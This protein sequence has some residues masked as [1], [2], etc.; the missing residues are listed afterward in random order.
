MKKNVNLIWIYLFLLPT[1]V[2]FMAFYAIPIVTMVL[3]SFTRWDGYNAPVFNGLT[4]YL[5]L[6]SQSAFLISLKNLFFWSAIAAVFHVGYGV[7]VA[8]I[9]YSKP[10]GWRFVRSV[11]MIPNVISAAALAMI[12]KFIFVDQYGLL[13]NL[14]R[15]A[16]P[17]FYI[18][19]FYQSPY[20]FWAVTFTWLFYAVIVTLIVMTDLYA[21]PPT[22]YESAVI[23]G[24]TQWDIS[25]KIN[26]PLCR[27]AIGTGVILSVTSRISMYVNIALTTRGGPGQDTTN[28]TLLQVRGI[29]DMHYGFANATSVIMLILGLLIL[30]VINKAFKM[31]ESVYF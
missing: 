26:L 18:N 23:D 7:L 27:N 9:L 8:F 17:D 10:F 31:K 13:N 14:V 24:A 29:T 1:F 19:W 3:T 28:L 4:N 2:I 6:F 5:N 30:L 15:L 21:V 20:A 16:I 22:L 12:Y 25:L 11:Y